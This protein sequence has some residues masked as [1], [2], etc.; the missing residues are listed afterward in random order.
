MAIPHF[1]REVLVADRRRG[2]RNQN[3]LLRSGHGGWRVQA[4]Y[5]GRDVVDGV[6]QV[7]RRTPSLHTGGSGLA[8]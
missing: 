3:R 8:C 7:L 6:I 2:P 5:Y 1:G 4:P